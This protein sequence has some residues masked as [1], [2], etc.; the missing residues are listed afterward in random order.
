[1]TSLVDSQRGLIRQ[2]ILTGSTAAIT[3][4]GALAIC[5]HIE[6]GSAAAGIN[7][8][9]QWIWGVRKARTDR[10]SLKHTA[11]GYA[12]HHATSIFW[13]LLY[14]AALGRRARERSTSA[15]GVVAQAAATTVA[16]YVVDYKLTPRRLQPGFEQHVSPRA[17][18]A[19]YAAFGAGLALATLLSRR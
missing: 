9:S 7:G 17:M 10:P 6:T 2:A 18:V 16:A 3:S 11:V 4:A 5:S 13:A 14:E 12:I 19:T 15:L 1:M 8:P